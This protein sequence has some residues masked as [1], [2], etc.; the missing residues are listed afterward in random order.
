[1]RELFSAKAALKNDDTENS[2]NTWLV[3]S[4]E[5]D[6]N[7]FIAV[8]MILFSYIFLQGEAAVRWL[9]E[10]PAEAAV[11]LHEMTSMVSGHG[12]FFYTL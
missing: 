9:C 12:S 3:F 7:Q 6:F 10:G 1:M 4:K 11:H 8:S 2:R 5:V